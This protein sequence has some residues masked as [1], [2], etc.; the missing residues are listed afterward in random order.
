MSRTVCDPMP[1][2]MHWLPTT[3]SWAAGL[4]ELAWP[5][6]EEGS[7]QITTWLGW[8]KTLPDELVYA[9]PVLSAW[10]A[11]ALFGRGEMEARGGPAEGRRTMAEPADSMKV[12][13]ETPSVE[14]VV[15][16]KVQ[17]G[18]L[19]AAIAV[20]HAYLAQA[21]GNIPDTVR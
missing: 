19:P 2:A 4:I 20:G 21:L 16:D 5:A 1:S 3:L 6:A 7:I 17:F 12:K 13:Q 18:S 11:Y 8:V 14:M 10:Y 9:R 15:V